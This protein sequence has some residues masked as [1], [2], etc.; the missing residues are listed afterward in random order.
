MTTISLDKKATAF[1]QFVEKWGAKLATAMGLTLETLDIQESDIVLA[2][3]LDKGKQSYPIKIFGNP[4]VIF[5]EKMDDKDVF[6]F[7]ELN[8]YLVKINVEG[9]F[10]KT[11]FAYTDKAEFNG[12]K[13]GR[14]E[15]AALEAFWHG[16]IKISRGGKLVYEQRLQNLLQIP[17]RQLADNVQPTQKNEPV[18]LV[19]K[20]RKSVV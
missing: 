13:D 10:A 19:R 4:S 11:W 6:L 3:P 18:A 7:S 5:E 14:T 8:A 12:A 2:V 20:D 16:K 9:D 15:A 17:D 1:A